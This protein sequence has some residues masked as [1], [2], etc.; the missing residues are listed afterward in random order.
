[1]LHWIALV[2]LASWLCFSS[3]SGRLVNSQF[4]VVCIQNVSRMYSCIRS[5]IIPTIA[6]CALQVCFAF[7]YS[8]DSMG[9]NV[10]CHTRWDRCMQQRAVDKRSERICQ[11]NCCS[12][13]L[14]TSNHIALC[15]S[16]IHAD[17]WLVASFY[18]QHWFCLFLWCFFPSY[19]RQ[20][21]SWYFISLLL[22]LLML[23]Y[24]FCN[25]F[26]YIDQLVDNSSYNMLYSAK[27][28]RFCCF[29]FSF[30][31]GLC[32]FFCLF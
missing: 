27:F 23:L 2:K 12:F 7:S 25:S 3:C 4:A 15:L 32:R 28:L 30:F 13:G 17:C 14:T 18:Y 9:S 16:C 20:Q 1:M 31:L 5:A 10:M 21:R 22:A 26:R 29:L 19:S 24:F 6:L 8:W 11:Y